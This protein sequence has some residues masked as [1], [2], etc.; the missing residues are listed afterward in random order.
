M[1]KCL[2][3]N[4]SSKIRNEIEVMNRLYA[5][6][7]TRFPHLI[8]AFEDEHNFHIVQE[9]CGGGCLTDK[10]FIKE[11]DVSI[12]IHNV[13]EG[14]KE[15]HGAGIIHKDI[16]HDNVL[17]LHDHDFRDLKIC[18]F[19]LSMQCDEDDE[20][21]FISKIRG[22]PWFLAPECSYSLVGLKSDVWSVGIMT[23]MMLSNSFPFL[24]HH[25][26][27]SNMAQLWNAIRNNEPLF[28]DE[29]WNTISPEAKDFVKLCLIKQPSARP[30]SKECLTHPWFG[31]SH[32]IKNKENIS[33]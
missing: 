30:S 18:D 31:S 10:Q 20:L 26:K 13:L 8:E 16:K 6:G 24:H 33:L 23:Y 32:C 5:K 25:V 27:T 22:T 11:V 21:V 15:I 28:V 1:K 7:V 17:F 12:V 2:P 14:L 4:N 19:G 29:I 3:G 9:L